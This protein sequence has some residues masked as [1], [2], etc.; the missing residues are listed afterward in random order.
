MW[1]KSPIHVSERPDVRIEVLRQSRLFCFNRDQAARTT[2][3]YPT[4]EAGERANLFGPADGE[5][6]FPDDFNPRMRLGPM[7]EPAVEFFHCIAAGKPLQG[8]LEA[9]WLENTAAARRDQGKS[10]AADRDVA[11]DILS[12][13][14]KSEGYAEGSVKIEIVR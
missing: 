12:R 3:L 14:R 7:P 6:K 13:L 4:G 5:L 2:L 1:A 8:V 10:G 11:G 9:R